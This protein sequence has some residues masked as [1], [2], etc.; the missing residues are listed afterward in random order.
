MTARAARFDLPRGCG[1]TADARVS[2]TRVLRDVEVRILS[3][4]L[5]EGRCIL[6][7]QA[8]RHCCYAP[9][10]PRTAD[11][12]S[13]WGAGRNLEPHVLLKARRAEPLHG[14]DDGGLTPDHVDGRADLDKELAPES[15]NTSSA[16][17]H[18]TLR[19]SSTWSCLPVSTAP[20][21]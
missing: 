9:L 21:E 13:G 17:F 3:P 15:E 11:P 20:R 2:G 1:G 4:A 6:G 8:P 18:L 12:R 7:V 16:Q 19:A 10:F 14:A 5:T